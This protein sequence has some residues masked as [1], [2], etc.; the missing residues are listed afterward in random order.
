MTRRRAAAAAVVVAAAVSA[1]G[2]TTQTAA[3]DTP[4]ASIASSPSTAASALAPRQPA[5]S[6]AGLLS[7]LPV[8][9]RA[10][11]TGYDRDLFGQAWADVDR[12][13]CDTRNDI[14]RRDLADI[15]LKP[16]THGCVV[17]SGVLADPYSGTTMPFQ[18]GPDTSVLVQ[19]DHVVALSDAWQKGA[20]QWAS[21]KRLAFAND[22]LELLAVDGRLNEQKSDS[23]AAS[24][25][26]PNRRFRCAY[27]ARQIAVKAK[28][29]LWVTTAERAAM[30]RV[31]A[32]C[33]G[34]AAPVGAA[35][36]L[37][38]F[39]APVTRH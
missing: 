26:P 21:R 20:G 18:R 27:V 17:L 35:P 31:L 8:K 36:T 16:G 2:A 12:N 6:A 25:L 23:D 15:S 38:P 33:P 22:P 14:L 32:G 39:D 28:Y 3:P 13:G 19:I 11:K 10:P 1:C 24:W 30:T 29:G 34:Q 37:A 9:G 4:T 7:Q 5:G